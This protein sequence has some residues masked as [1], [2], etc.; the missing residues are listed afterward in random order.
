[1][2]R[3]CSYA[4]SRCDDRRLRKFE[5][6]RGATS[7]LSLPR[8]RTTHT[9]AITRT[10]AHQEFALEMDFVLEGD[11][12]SMHILNVVSPG[13]T[14]AMPFAEYVVSRIETLAHDSSARSSRAT[15]STS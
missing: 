15:A 6:H 8:S 13:F 11:A 10:G 9:S 1:M 12:Q 14:C 4:M 7:S 2:A 3:C 5:N